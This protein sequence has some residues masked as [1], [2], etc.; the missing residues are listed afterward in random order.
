MHGT[1]PRGRDT[2]SLGSLPKDSH[3]CRDTG[4]VD[5]RLALASR[6]VSPPCAGLGFPDGGPPCP[7]REPRTPWDPS[8]HGSL[9]EGGDDD[10]GK[11]TAERGVTS[12]VTEPPLCRSGPGLAS[13]P[14]ARLRPPHA[15]SQPREPWRAGGPVPL[16]LREAQSFHRGQAGATVPT[17][18]LGAEVGLRAE[19]KGLEG[20]ARPSPRAPSSP[21]RRPGIRR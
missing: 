2:T 20:W 11:R 3:P 10:F 17:A 21:P 14:T 7:G 19:V 4:R 18:N 15:A 5:R 1:T 13:W 12:H 9:G 8:R 6:A 16:G